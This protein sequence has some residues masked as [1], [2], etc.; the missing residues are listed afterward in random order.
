[1]H[2]T[3][4]LLILCWNRMGKYKWTWCNIKEGQWCLLCFVICLIICL[5]DVAV[6]CYCCCSFSSWRSFF[7]A[8]LYII[9][10]RV[11]RY[12]CSIVWA[13][14]CLHV[15]VWQLLLRYHGPDLQNI[16]QQSYNYLTIMPK[17]RSTYNSHVI[18][19]TSYEGRKTFL[20]YSSLQKS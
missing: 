13:T 11:R 14:L 8:C 18:Y 12:C 19:K 2:S 4:C 5:I 3:K 7:C 1:M 10:E 17:L 16:L 20:R 9:T 15:I 6:C